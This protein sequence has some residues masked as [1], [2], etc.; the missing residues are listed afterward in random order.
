MTKNLQITIIF[1]RKLFFE[2]LESLLSDAGIKSLR[3]KTLKEINQ[4]DD[5][6]EL[7]IIELDTKKTIEDLKK[8]NKNHIRNKEIICIA[9]PSLKLIDELKDIRTIKKPFSFFELLNLIN[10]I[11]DKRSFQKNFVLGNI[12]YVS[13]QAKFINTSNNIEIKLTDLENKLILFIL[14][15]K[16]GVS[17]KSIL[18]NVWRHKT[19]LNTHTLESLIYRLR[20]KIEDDPNNP[21]ILKQI[22]KKYFL[23][24]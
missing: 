14:K 11:K 23:K 5:S 2:E 8:L 15:N 12:I 22:Q 1:K 13:N 24:T 6:E 20:R 16:D 18:Q 17:K 3:N 19:D 10:K 9:E 4:L 7:L 21:K